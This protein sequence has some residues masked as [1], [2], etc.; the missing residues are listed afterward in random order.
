MSQYKIAWLPGDGVGRDVM[1]AARIV[2]DAIGLDADSAETA[3]TA[4]TRFVSRAVAP[5]RASALAIAGIAAFAR[6][7]D[8]RGAVGTNFRC[9]LARP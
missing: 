7:F 3:A 2:L 8:P 1:E 9:A 6:F 4:D 5:A